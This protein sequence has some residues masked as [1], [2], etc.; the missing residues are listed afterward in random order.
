MGRRVRHARKKRGLS[1]NDLAEAVGMG[2]PDI[3]KIERGEIERTTGIARIARALLVPS[4]WLEDGVG[5][6]PDWWVTLT[7]GGP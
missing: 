3:S 2:Q 4:E 7:S 5:D 6:E 1:Q